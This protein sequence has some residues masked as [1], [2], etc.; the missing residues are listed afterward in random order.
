M[1]VRTFARPLPDGVELPTEFCI[2]AAGLNDTDKGPVLFDK[3]AA[4]AIMA[5]YARRGV[6]LMI[7]LN[8]DSLAEA[9]RPDSGDARGWFKP[10][11]REDGSLWA[12]D[13]KWTPDGARRLAEKTQRY[14]SPAVLL[15][16]ED[17]A[18]VLV[19]CAIVAMPATYD[20]PALVAASRVS[21][22]AGNTPATVRGKMDPEQIKAAIDA[23][24]DG[25]MA[26]A[27]G[28]DSSASPS[29]ILDA[30]QAAVNALGPSSDPDSSADNP[31]PDPATAESADAPPMMNA[32]AREL[33]CETAAEAFEKLK[34]L[35][36]RVDGLDTE[37]SALD[38]AKRTELVGELVKLEAETPATAW[39]GDPKDRKVCARLAAESVD[40]MLSRVTSL[41]ATRATR[42]TKTPPTRIESPATQKKTYSREVLAHCKKLG[43]TTEEF[44]ARK[45]AS[46]RRIGG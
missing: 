35:K 26:K 39:D 32:F 12:C 27:L 36:A 17:R 28:L 16:G 1:K 14:I 13:V 3:A 19:N 46:V 40:A 18:L 42:A 7:D 30:V 34:T 5:D 43:I 22:A 23:L 4:D 41:R 44:E 20:A 2:F 29:D 8:H 38:N 31:A 6:D 33:G 15:D 21:L 45:A 11:V 9:T 10:Q 37:Q 25:S 24:T